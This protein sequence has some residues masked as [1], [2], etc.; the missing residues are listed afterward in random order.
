ME[1]RRLEAIGEEAL[2]PLRRGWYLGSE[3]FKEQ[4]LELMEGKLGESLSGELHRE[5][6]EQRA[7]RIIAEERAR[8]VPVIL[9]ISASASGRLH[10]TCAPVSDRDLDHNFL[11]QSP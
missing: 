10:A 1:W 7:N 6:A 3:Q 4:M 2:E 8:V 9:H 11:L 5:T